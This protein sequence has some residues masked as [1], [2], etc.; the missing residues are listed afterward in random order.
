MPKLVSGKSL[1]MDEYNHRP[2]CGIMLLHIL[3][4]MWLFIHAEIQVN[5]RQ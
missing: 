1:G 2:L 4:D 5:P 3:L